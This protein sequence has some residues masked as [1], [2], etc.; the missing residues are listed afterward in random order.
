MSKNAGKAPLGNKSFSKVKLEGPKMYH[1]D[2][3]LEASYPRH[4]KTAPSQH[5]EK[6]YNPGAPS[7]S[8][9]GMSGS[10][11]NAKCGKDRKTTHLKVNETD[12]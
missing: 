9:I 12:H 8:M 6:Q 11:F 5:W 10:D 1:D 3:G 4:G 7:G 2:H